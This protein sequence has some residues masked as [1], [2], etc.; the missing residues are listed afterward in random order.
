MIVRLGNRTVRTSMDDH[1]LAYPL[2]KDKPLHP[3]TGDVDRN[4]H[5]GCESRRQSWVEVR[6]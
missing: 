1:T 6:S 2:T 5:A 3:L 4:G